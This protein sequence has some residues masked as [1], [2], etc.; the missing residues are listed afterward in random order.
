M[1]SQVLDN[2]TEALKRKE[3]DYSPY[4]EQRPENDNSSTER[5]PRLNHSQISKYES[6]DAKAQREVYYNKDGLMTDNGGSSLKNLKAA[7]S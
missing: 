3:N 6:S 7:S 1:I 4:G 2:Y 5:L